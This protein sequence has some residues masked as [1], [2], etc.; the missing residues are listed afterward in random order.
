[1]KKSIILG[2]LAVL[3]LTASCDLVK[4]SVAGTTIK[5]ESS[6]NVGADDFAGIK[7]NSY[8]KTGPAGLTIVQ[9]EA[10][11]IAKDVT[12][13]SEKTALGSDLVILGDDL[14]EAAKPVRGTSDNAGVLI[15]L[16]ND[17]SEPVV[18]SAVVDVDGKIVNLPEVTVPASSETETLFVKHKE[19]VDILDTKADDVVPVT[20]LEEVI[21]G[22][23]NE[24]KVKDIAVKTTATKAAAPAAVSGKITVGAKYVTA[25]SFPAGTVI[26]I[27]KSFEDLNISLDRLNV[28]VFNEYDVYLTVTNPLPFSIEATAI[29]ES[30]VTASSKS[31]VKA[32]SPESPVTSEAVIRVVD[33]SGE[34]VSNIASADLTLKLTAASNGAKIPADANL[35]I[36]VDK[37][38]VVAE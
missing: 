3:A 35:K 34:K 18:L 4:K 32:G 6:S 15:S 10:T 25:L 38:V 19:T 27:N 7:G 21:G 13:S 30:N 1:M 2:A 26:T 29:S 33:H 12:L 5:V 24:L 28:Y 31:A 17:L 36:S 22:D 9:K 8:A 20:G 16:K 14:P 11:P 37:I 23:F